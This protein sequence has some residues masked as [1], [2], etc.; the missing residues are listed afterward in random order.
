MKL[1]FKIVIFLVIIFG[2]ISATFLLLSINSLMNSQESNLASFRNEFVELSRELFQNSA[3]IFFDYFDH[4]IANGEFAS[5]EGAVNFF[6]TVD[7]QGEKVILIDMQ[8]KQFMAGYGAAKFSSF[9]DKKTISS[10]TEQW[11]LNEKKD[12]EVDNYQEFLA[13]KTSL[14]PHQINI[15]IYD[16][17]G[18]IVGYGK[19]FETAKV[20]VDFIK[21]KTDEYARQT[22]ELSIIIFLG[23]AILISLLAIWFMKRTIINP[24]VKLKDATVEIGKGKLGAKIKISSK[25]EIGEL[26]GSFNLM[27]K[28]LLSS[29]QSIE[30]NIKE[31]SAEHGKLSSLVE[32]V[33]LGVVM[34]DLNMNVIMA[35]SAAKIILGKTADDKI[36]F[37]DLAAK[38]KDKIDISHA[39]SYYV[40]SGSPVNIQEVIIGEKYFRLFMSPVRDITE[41]IFIGAV[42][43]MEDVTEQKK[44]D[45]MRTEIISIT[46]HQLRTPSTIIKVN[47][48][49]I[50][51]N[52]AG[53]LSAEQEEILHDIYSGNQRIIRLIDDLMDAAKIEEGKFKLDAQ[54]AQLE[55]IV[56]EVIKILEPL[57]RDKHVSLTFDYPPAPL[58]PVKV[59]SPKIHQVIQ[60]IVDNAIKY[61]SVGDKGKVEVKIVEGAKFLELVVKDNGIGIP[62]GE[63]EKMFERFSRGSN[64][65]KLDPGG[66]NGLG[67]YIAKAVVEQGGGK[68]WFTSKQEEGTIFHVT[69]PFN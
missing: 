51:N 17:L 69:F 28:K 32:S 60:N 31:L 25:D 66:G 55:K 67:L 46:S 7:P 59:N 39:L 56:G 50:M 1:Y 62:E 35:N 27:S 8:S 16:S 40:R 63:Q 14:V 34:V 23:I 37:D 42:I 4:G 21:T 43:V 68:I 33:K 12:F 18:L 36:V 65:T 20:R 57:A 64:S 47:L 49:T 52:G 61:S 38:V 26:A 2:L 45:R 24:L 44:L 41:K 15:K 5:K 6:H 19:V 11:V 13:G 9:L 58:P 48:E 10:F 54:P 22:R 3:D 29:R 30:A 53:P